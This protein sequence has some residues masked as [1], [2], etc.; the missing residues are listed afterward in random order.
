MRAPKVLEEVDGPG[1]LLEAEP[2]K[3]QRV[4]VLRVGRG[5]TEQLLGPMPKAGGGTTPSHWFISEVNHR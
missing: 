3:E 2:T 4:N 5:I 1:A